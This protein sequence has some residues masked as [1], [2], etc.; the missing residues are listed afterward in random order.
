MFLLTCLAWETTNVLRHHPTHPYGTMM[1]SFQDLEARKA[2]IDN[3]LAIDGSTNLIT[4]YDCA[5]KRAYI[6]QKRE[7]LLYY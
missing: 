1:A 6:C 3:C 2:Q 5:S 4:S 7:H